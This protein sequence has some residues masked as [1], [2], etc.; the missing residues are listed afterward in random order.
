MEHGKGD[1]LDKMFAADP[2]GVA[3]R[4]AKPMLAGYVGI[5]DFIACAAHGHPHW[6]HPQG[7]Q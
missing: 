1:G 6:R 5:R 3:Y 7:K 4:N 2:A